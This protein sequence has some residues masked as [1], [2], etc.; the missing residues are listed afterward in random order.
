[1]L[2]A[3]LGTAGQERL[4]ATRVCL[5]AADDSGAADVARAYLERAGL[6]LTAA[7][8]QV[9]VQADVTV[10]IAGDQ[11]K[12]LAGAPELEACAAVLLGAW[13]AVEVIK[14]SV[15]VGTAA[16]FPSAWILNAEVL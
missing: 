13:T 15:G 11:V 3:E 2:L 6:Q 5:C 4:C 8:V 10:S 12:K 9:N 7:G 14:Q 16:D 1:V